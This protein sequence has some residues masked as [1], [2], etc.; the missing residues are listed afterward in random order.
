MRIDFSV[1]SAGVARDSD[2]NEILGTHWEPESITVQR[3]VRINGVPRRTS[4]LVG[5]INAVMFSADDLQLVFGPPTVRRRYLDI[6]IS[7]M[8]RRYLSALQRYQRVV[9]QRN[10]LLRMLR[11]GRSAP[12]E[13]RYWDDELVAHGKYVMARRM[14]TVRRLSELAGPIHRELTGDGESLE[15]IYRPSVQAGEGDSEDELAQDFMQALEAHRRQEIAQAVT[16]YGPHRDD[17]QL[18]INGMDAG[19]YASRGQSRTAVLSMKLAEAEHLADQVHAEPLLLLDDIMSELDARRRSQV[20]ERAGQYR[21][22]FIT[23]TDAAVVDERFRAGMYNLSVDEG[24]VELVARP[25]G[26]PPPSLR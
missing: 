19:V 13:L 1:A 12:D 20:V 2:A 24:R 11:E 26:S 21:Q 17:I 8:D 16:L 7:Q 23:T 22:C 5:N 15:L 10:H 25:A 18:R 6:V 3:Y 14:G 4:E 9:Y